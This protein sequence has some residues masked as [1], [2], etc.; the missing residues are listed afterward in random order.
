MTTEGTLD[1]GPTSAIP[2]VEVKQGVLEP[3]S[4][5][6]SPQQ[7]SVARIQKTPHQ[8]ELDVSEALLSQ[9]KVHERLSI[10]G[11]PAPFAFDSKGNLC[12]F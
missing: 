10:V 1:W 3:M 9:V 11:E 4:S 8:T 6:P 12:A 2:L 7:A 5:I